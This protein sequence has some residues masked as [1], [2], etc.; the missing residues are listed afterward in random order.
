M[1]TM[2]FAEFLQD[3]PP[4]K[5]VKITNLWNVESVD[6]EELNLNIP[7]LWLY[8]DS[9]KC[10][11]IRAFSSRQT[12]KYEIFERNQV[13]LYRC[14]NCQHKTKHI[15][16]N[17]TLDREDPGLSV[18]QDE[19]WEIP[20]VAGFA[21]NYGEL[22]PF[23]PPTPSRLIKLIGPDRNLFLKGRRSENLGLGVGA[24]AYYRQVV[25]RQKDRLITEIAKVAQKH[26]ASVET[27]ELFGK[28]INETQFSK[29]V[30]EIRDAIPQA[31]LIDGHNPLSLLH[32]ALSEGIHAGTDEDCLELAT[33]IRTIL[34]KLSENITHVLKDEAELKNSLTRLLN[35][36]NKQQA[37]PAPSG[38]DTLAIERTVKALDKPNGV[39]GETKSGETTSEAELKPRNGPIPTEE[40][41]HDRETGV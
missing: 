16:L 20:S 19:V 1:E 33:A 38:S 25:E 10:E 14:C 2:A 40:N 34:A 30:H 15:S 39:N 28:A 17:M 41:T 32:D 11:G 9:E 18:S 36:K 7:K 6:P 35:R 23:G 4:S 22:P 8:C 29:A 24:F 27:L 31:L 13:L 5:R 12:I 21:I 26:G 37:L 3:I